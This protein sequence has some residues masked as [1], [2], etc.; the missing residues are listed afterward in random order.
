MLAGI[1]DLLLISS[2]EDAPLFR[3]L[4]GDGSQWGIRIGYAIQP[5]PSGIAQALLIGA[6]FIGTERALRGGGVRR[7]RACDRFG[8]SAIIDAPEERSP[9]PAP[10]CRSDPAP[11]CRDRSRAG[12]RWHR[13][14]AWIDASGQGLRRLRAPSAAPSAYSPSL[15]ASAGSSVALGDPATPAHTSAARRT[16]GSGSHRGGE[17]PLRRRRPSRASPSQ[18]AASPRSCAAGAAQYGG[19]VSRSKCSLGCR[20]P[21]RSYVDT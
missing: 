2:P 8:G 15:A 16:P 3:R 21:L 6:D 11:R 9:V 20:C 10:S 7:C 13:R 14:A 17:R 1:R 12:S 18:S 4:L 5:A 19:P